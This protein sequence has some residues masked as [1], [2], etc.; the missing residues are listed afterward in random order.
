M[1]FIEEL[2]TADAPPAPLAGRLWVGPG[3]A[4]AAA[5]G[6]I[7][8]LPI[9]LALSDVERN[10][11]ISAPSPCM[12]AAP[13]LDR[14]GRVLAPVTCTAVW[15]QLSERIVPPPPV[16]TGTCPTSSFSPHP[17]SATAAAAGDG[18]IYAV[19]GGT[20][21]GLGPS[22]SNGQRRGGVIW[23]A[24]PAYRGPALIRGGR[25]EAGHG[26]GP[27]VVFDD[28]DNSLRFDLD[29][30]V[31]AGDVSEGSAL[32]WR[33]LPSAVYLPGAGC[34]AFEIDLPDRTTWIVLATSP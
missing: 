29:T 17:G 26:W 1:P 4:L 16:A 30:H 31:R 13:Q 5:L 27:S 20:T 21:I 28:G 14:V 12:T 3:R 6:L 11:A 2:E 10:G 23:V 34:Y 7:V 9:V 25:L 32:G 18:P 24:S 19:T 22:G 33:Y 15:Q 8:A